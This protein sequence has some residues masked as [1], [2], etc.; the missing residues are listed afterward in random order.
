MGIKY[1]IG[2]AARMALETVLRSPAFPLTRYFPRGVVWMYDAQRFVGTRTLDLIF[3]VGANIGQT[4]QGLLR[5]FPA[6]KIY[7]FEPVSSSFAIL[8]ARYSKRVIC[9]QL[10][11]GSEAAEKEIKL[12][13]DPEM[14]SF[15]STYQRPGHYTGDSEFVSVS[16]VDQI[17]LEH[18]ITAIDVLKM[19][20]QGWELEVLRGA[21]A[22]LGSNRVRFI[23]TEVGFRR[24]DAEMV[25]FGD[26]LDAAISQLGF[27]FCGFYDLFRY[28]RAKEFTL[29]GN[30][31]YLNPNFQR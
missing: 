23:F 10:A 18:G 3:D 26:L 15:L 29:F 20:V 13:D 25:M 1:R 24:N 11:L 28:G 8:S 27:L 12:R 17:C 31:L 4:A 2:A 22:M 6:A 16:T 5:F 14:N 21:S 19:D 30:A 9:V 7:C